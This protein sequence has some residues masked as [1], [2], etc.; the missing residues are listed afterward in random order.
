VCDLQV[1]PVDHYYYAELS[2]DGVKV[3]DQKHR[4]RYADYVPGMLYASPFVLKTADGNVAIAPPT[5]N[6]KQ[7]S[8][9]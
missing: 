5:T 7:G 9:F 6:T 4:V 1:V 2:F 8:L 3:Y